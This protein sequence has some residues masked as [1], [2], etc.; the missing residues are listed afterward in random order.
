MGAN[1]G[2][3]GYP[4]NTAA[5]YHLIRHG[6]H[7]WGLHRMA[8]LLFHVE[9][10]T[11]YGK[12]SDQHSQGQAMEGIYSHTAQRRDGG[13]GRWIRGRAGVS[14]AQWKRENRALL[15]DGLIRKITRRGKNDAH[16]ATE[17]IPDW[18]A[19]RAALEEHEFAAAP[20]PQP[21][22]SQPINPRTGN[23]P[24]A[25]PEP[26]PWLPQSQPLAP[27][28]P[29]PWLPQSHTVVDVPAVESTVSESRARGLAAGQTEDT[30]ALFPAE[31][32]ANTTSAAQILEL[33]EGLCGHPLWPNDPTPGQI[34]ADGQRQGVPALALCYFLQD[35]A[36]EFRQRSYTIT[37]PGLFVSAT[38]TDLIAWARG[39]TNIIESTAREERQAAFRAQCAA[40]ALAELPAATPSP[41]EEPN[42]ATN[43]QH[44]EPTA[45][46]RTA[47][48][49]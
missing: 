2:P 13:Q 5:I 36:E 30:H 31:E 44:D 11:A 29:T 20:R 24:L 27:A 42:A 40:G 17:F 10:S 39:H 4:S 19:I 7:I 9:R 43:A 12:D 21:L 33:L 28:E 48:G 23:T 37:S 47:Q 49:S 34:L 32:E 16:Q 1:S 25:L 45:N 8:V 46:R 35:K 22:F 38:R 14:R 18:L 3:S 6:F 41:Q 15:K 26:S